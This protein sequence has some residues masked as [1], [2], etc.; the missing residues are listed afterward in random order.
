MRIGVLGPLEVRADTGSL[1]PVTGA[2]LRSLLI[3]LAVEEGRPVPVD[4]LTRLAAADPMP[5]RV[6]HGEDLTRF[7]AG[8]KPVRDANASPLS[9]S[10]CASSRASPDARRSVTRQYQRKP[11]KVRSPV[12]YAASKPRRSNGRPVRMCRVQGL[13]A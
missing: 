11:A 5:G 7:T 6:L 8:A 13:V 3:R 4:R 9:A 1:V 2:R 12:W 10:R